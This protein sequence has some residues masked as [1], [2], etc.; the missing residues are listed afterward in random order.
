VSLEA[1]TAVFARTDLPPYERLVMLALADRADDELTCFPSIADICQRTGMAERGVQNVLNRLEQTGFLVI[2]R[3]GGRHTRNGY[4]LLI[5]HENPARHAPIAEDKPR[6]RNPVSHAETPHPVQETPHG[7][8]LN[9]APGAHEP[10]LTLIEPRIEDT[11]SIPLNQNPEPKARLPA[12]WALSDEG[13]AYARSKQIPD[14]DIRDEATGFH[15]YW[16]DRGEKKSKRG[17]EQTWANRV[18]S[19]AGRYAARGRMAFQA[20][21]G[22][23]G[24]GSSIASIVA[25]RRIEGTV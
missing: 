7:I 5:G 22:R 15:A 6:T 2:R 18:R 1:M 8:T 20:G 24:Q 11:P 16:T 9:P 10:S 25:R 17:W 13:W 19:I 21:P 12:D 4:I 3:G 14:E 23:H